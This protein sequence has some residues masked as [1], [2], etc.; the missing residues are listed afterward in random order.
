MNNKAKLTAL[1]NVVKKKDNTILLLI[2]GVVVL[3]GIYLLWPAS[4]EKWRK[5]HGPPT[6]LQFLRSKAHLS[7][8]EIARLN[9]LESIRK[10]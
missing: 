6:E 10:N 1:K 5:V 4:D 9:Y 3:G 2:G 7:D 8:E